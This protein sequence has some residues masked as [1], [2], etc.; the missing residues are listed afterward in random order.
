[1]GKGNDPG[2]R[3]AS[4][5]PPPHLSEAELSAGSGLTAEWKLHI[6]SDSPAVCV[7]PLLNNV[8]G[9][10]L[11]D[12]LSFQMFQCRLLCFPQTR[13]AP[14]EI[15]CLKLTFIPTICKQENKSRTARCYKHGPIKGG[16]RDLREGLMDVFAR[17]VPVSRVQ[18]AIDIRLFPSFSCEVSPEVQTSALNLWVLSSAHSFHRSLLSCYSRSFLSF[19]R[20][21]TNIQTGQKFESLITEDQVQ[22]KKKKKKS[23]RLFLKSPVKI[24]SVFF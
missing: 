3:W 21:A 16:K 17:Q 7:S 18:R 2:L 20:Q 9:D 6:S 12:L 1:M 15:C 10:V 19:Q 23:S 4:E 5:A 22:P 14:T 8:P 24:L 11:L 13:E